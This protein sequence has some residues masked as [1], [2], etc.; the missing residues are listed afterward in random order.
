[1]LRF[2]RIF[3]GFTSSGKVRWLRSIE[4][5][6]QLSRAVVRIP[7]NVEFFF[8]KGFYKLKINNS[9]YLQYTFWYSILCIFLAFRHIAHST[10]CPFDTLSVRHF[11]CSTL[12]PFDTLSVRHFVHLTLVFWHFV[13]L[14]LCANFYMVNI[15]KRDFNE[16]PPPD[17][18]AETSTI[19]LW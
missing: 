15:E 9:F 8:S 2:Y 5:R 10:S 19:P 6:G 1:M 13:L 4:V 17:A 16:R 11:V 12:C 3:S 14:L 7:N 18:T